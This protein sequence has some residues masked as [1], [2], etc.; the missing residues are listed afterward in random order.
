MYI[1]ITID[2]R[3]VVVD[4]DNLAYIESSKYFTYFSVSYT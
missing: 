3:F 2:N 1:F 4:S